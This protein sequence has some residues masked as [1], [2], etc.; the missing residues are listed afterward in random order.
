MELIIEELT[1]TYKGDIQALDRVSLRMTNG[2]FGLLGPNGAGKS[3]LMQILSAIIPPTSGEIRYGDLRIGRDDQAIRRLLGYL[4]QSF[5][6]YN[7]LTG[8]EFLEYIAM[9]KGIPAHAQRK[10]VAEILE[11]VNLAQKAKKKIRT[12]SGG[13]KQRIGIAQAMLGDPQVIIVDEPTAGLDPEERIRFRDMLEELGADKIVLLS[14]HIVADIEHACK[15]LAILAKGKV[16]FQG[17]PEDLISLVNGKVWMGE[18]E[19]LARERVEGRC[20]GRRRIANGFELRVIADG[21]PF[22]G[23]VSV[24][25]SLEDGYMAFAGV[26]DH[27]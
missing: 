12:Y 4:P 24:S 21:K 22:A 16:L 2:I 13:M 9:L 5:G 11:K 26:T 15:E 1:K 8:E 18:V 27:E 7:K 14:T 10:Q 6:L 23:A 3:T 20:I 19:D 17:R 25:P